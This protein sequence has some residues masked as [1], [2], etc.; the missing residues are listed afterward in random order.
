MKHINSNEKA[1]ILHTMCKSKTGSSL[2]KGVVR[3]RIV[4]VCKMSEEV[5]EQP[6]ED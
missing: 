4:H 3:I 2:P 6:D 1:V 5:H